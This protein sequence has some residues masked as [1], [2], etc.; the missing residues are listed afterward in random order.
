M[1]DVWGKDDGLLIV[2]SVD[3][4]PEML[5]QYSLDIEYGTGAADRE[6][7]TAAGRATQMH[8]FHQTGVYNIQAVLVKEVRNGYLP[9]SRMVRIV[10]YREEIVSLYNE[11][12]A[13]L[14]SQ[15]FSFTPRMTVR[16]VEARLWQVYPALSSGITNTLVTVF[17]E[18]NYSL[19]PIARPA[20]EKMFRA[21]KEVEKHILK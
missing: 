4:S 3:G 13:S 17:E 8:I 11:M 1:P 18:A 16:E 19:H 6:A 21:V 2:F 15:D 20:Y 12:L 7:L 5:A 9:A 14:E 10:D